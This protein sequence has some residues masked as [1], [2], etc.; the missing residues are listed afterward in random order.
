MSGSA[1]AAKGCHRV[2]MIRRIGS[3]AERHAHTDVGGTAR[4]PVTINLFIGLIEEIAATG[5]HG[6]AA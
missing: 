1:V 3:A 4:G 2:P 5:K 6:E